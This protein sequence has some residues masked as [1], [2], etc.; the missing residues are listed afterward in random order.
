[1]VT[2]NSLCPDCGEYLSSFNEHKCPP[3]WQAIRPDYCDEHDESTYY[4]AFGYTAEDAALHIAENNFSNWDYPSEVEIWVRRS[5]TDIWE[6]F[7]VY[8]LSVPSFTCQK[9]ESET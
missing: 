5:L 9:M 3:K 4:A 2:K 1:M 6:K 8:V 7:S